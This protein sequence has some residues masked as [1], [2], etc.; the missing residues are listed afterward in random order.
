ME[1]VNVKPS[2]A[3]DSAVI[4]APDMAPP[5]MKAAMSNEYQ[6]ICQARA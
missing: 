4:I 3:L 5:T 6:N 2:R 1:E